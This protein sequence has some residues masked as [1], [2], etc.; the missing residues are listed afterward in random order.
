MTENNNDDLH[1]SL[2]FEAQFVKGATPG[3]NEMSDELQEMKENQFLF[4]PIE[5]HG[6]ND[7]E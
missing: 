7:L 1:D 3:E 2:S 4:P 6:R 5:P